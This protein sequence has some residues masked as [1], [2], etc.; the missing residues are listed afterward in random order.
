V[1]DGVVAVA[2]LVDEAGK[3]AGRGE[4]AATIDDDHV[5]AALGGTQ[6]IEG[7]TKVPGNFLS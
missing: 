2:R 7:I 3:G 4:A 1:F 5:I 6:R